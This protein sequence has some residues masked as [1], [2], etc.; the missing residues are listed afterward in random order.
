MLIHQLFEAQAERSP[1]ALAA[2]C[3]EAQLTYQELN[4]QANQLAHHLK[5][6]GVGPGVY[7]AVYM[8]RS[9][10]ILPALLGILKAGGAYV[11]LETSFP[12]ARVR[13]ILSSLHIPVVITH[14]AYVSSIPDTSHLP[15]LKHVICLNEVG[16]QRASVPI[17]T[18]SQLTNLPQ[19]NPFSQASQQNLAYV[20]FTSGSTGTPKGV[21]V[22]HQPVINLITWINTTFQVQARDRILFVTS[23][24]FD[25]SVYDVFGVLAVGGSI[26]IATEQDLRDPEQLISLLRHEPITF[27][28]SAP[29]VFQQVVP[30][31]PTTARGPETSQLRL[32]FL[33]GDWIP[34]GL[35]DTIRRTFARAQVVSL[36]GATETTVWS[37][38]HPI[39]VV[40][41]AW[42][43]IPYGWP[44][45]NI[46]CFILDSD[47]RPCPVGVDG[48][49]YVGGICLSNGYC[50]EPALT[51]EKF[52]PDPFSEE[53]G[54]RL[55]MTGD[56][57]RLWPDGNI[58]FLGRADQQV[59]VRGFRIELGEI[60][61][62]LSQYPI[63]QEVAVVAREYAAREKRLIA[64]LVPRQ[65]EAYDE[66]MGSSLP[67]WSGG[68]ALIRHLRQFLQE[69]L[70]EYMLPSAYML[71]EKLPLT[72]N[73][74]IDRKALPEPLYEDTD[75]EFVAPRTELEEAL[76]AVWASVLGLQ[77]V[78]IHDNFFLAGGHSL[79]ATLVITRVRDLCQVDLPLSSLFHAQTVASFANEVAA[80]RKPERDQEYFRIQ[81]VPRSRRYHPLSFPQEQV[82][83]LL[84]LA[85]QNMAYHFQA[86]LKMKG[87]LNTSA[88][89]KSLDEIIRRH[90]IF[91]TTFESLNG[92]PV[93]II[94][95]P[96]PVR[97]AIIDLCAVPE[98]ERAQLVQGILWQAFRQ[99]FAP[100]TLPLIRW[101]LL[102]LSEQEY[103]LTHIEH[104]LVHDGWSFN[105]FLHELLLLYRAFSEHQISPLPELPV[106][107]VDFVYWQRQWVESERGREQL[108]Y[109]TAQLAGSPPL[110]E[111]PIDHPRPHIQTF[112]GNV[113]RVAL[114]PRLCEALRACC[115]REGFTLYMVMLA[116]FLA[117][118]SRY[119]GQEDICLGTGIANRRSREA[120]LLIGMLINTVVLRADL[121]GNP[122][123]RDLLARVR[124]LTLEAYEHQD[125]PFEKV[126]AAL[127]PERDLSYNPFFQ[128]IFGFHDSPLDALELPGMELNL[129]EALS[130]GSA[131]FDLNLIVIPRAEQMVA[132]SP[133][134]KNADII[135]LWEYNSD[136]FE[137]ATMQRMLA[138]YQMLLEGVCTN[139][140]QR[141]ADVALL[142][143]EELRQQLVTWNE[144]GLALPVTASLQQ[145]IESWAWQAPATNALEYRGEQISYQ[146]LNQ[147]ANQ[148][149]HYLRKLGVGP[150]SLVGVCLG[151][152]LNLV[153]C[154]LAILKTGGAYL[155][156]DPA[157]PAERLAFM[158]QDARTVVLL[159]TNALSTRFA[160]LQERADWTRTTRIISLESE[161]EQIEQQ[162]RTGLASEITPDH[163]AYVIYTSGSTGNPKGVQITYR[164]LLNLVC[165]HQRAFSLTSQ[166]RTSQLASLSFD[167]AG[168][169]IWPSLAAGATLCIVDDETRSFPRRLRDWLVEQ[170]ITLS[171]LP[172]PLAESLLELEWPEKVALR[173]LL[174]GGDL[175][176][177]A[178]TS[179]GSFVLVN[180]YGPTEYSVVGTSG[181]VSPIQ[182]TNWQPSIG[183]PIA[184][185][186]VY[187][188]DHHMQPVPP[189]VAGE[190][191]LGGAGL[192]RG[193]AYR[194]DLTAERFLPDPFSQ[195]PGDRLY[196]TGDLV[197]YRPDGSLSFLGRNDE[198]VK[199]RGFRIELGEI[200]VALR[201]H[202]AIQEAL[203]VAREDIPGQKQLVAYL[204][205][206]T[207]QS[208]LMEQ[209]RQYLQD[210]FPSY[211]L[212]S[213]LVILEKLPL[214][215]NGKLDRRALPPPGS[216]HLQAGSIPPRT[217]IEELLAGMWAEVLGLQHVGI[218]ENF[219]EMGG[220]SLLATQVIARIH[221]LFQV[222][223]PLRSLF[224]HPCVAEL[225]LV[226]SHSQDSPQE[227]ALQRF[228]R[229]TR[230]ATQLPL[231]FA[232]QRLWFLHQL[233]PESPFYNISR[234]ITLTGPLQRTALAQSLNELVRRHEV[235]RTRFETPPVQII[236]LA[237]SLSLPVE[238]LA[239]LPEKERA[240][241]VQ[242]L[243]REEV[244]RPFDLQQGPL[245]RAKLLCLGTQEHMLLLSL[246]HIVSDGWSMSVL[247][248]ELGALYTAFCAGL[249]SPLPDLPLQYA[250]YALWQRTT[251][252]RE[253]WQAQL[254]YWK[255]QLAHL[256]QLALPTDR[257]RPATQTFAGTYE[258]FHLSSAITAQ[259]KALSRR[260]EVTLFM[261]LLAG[262]Q[263]LLARYSNQTDIVVGTGT[264]NRTRKELENLIG[265]FINTLV[266]RTDLSGDPSVH[267]LLG[268][269]RE[270]AL[271]AYA[272]QNLPFEQLVEELHP[273]RR[274][275]ANPLFQVIIALQN[276]PQEPLQLARLK[277]QLAPIHS[278][279]TKFDLH[280]SLWEEADGL[281]GML[282]YSTD[283]FEAGTIQRMLGHYQHILS[284]M[285]LQ[286]AQRISALPLLTETEL[287]QLRT[288][289]ATQKDYP[290]DTGLHR[291]FERQVRQTPQATAVSF[292]DEGIVTYEQLNRQANQLARYLC[293]A[294][295]RPGEPVGLYMERSLDLVISLLAI[296]KA[297]AAYAPLDLAYPR[298][299]VAFMIEDS[300]MRF[301]LTQQTLLAQLPEQ[302]A[303]ALCLD[304]EREKI[305]RQATSNLDRDLPGL[306]PAYVI[307]TSGSTG[308]PKGAIV[309][310]QAVARL[311]INT[312]YIQINA[313]DHFA[314]VSNA[315]FDAATFEIWG[316][317][318]HG[319]QLIGV[320]RD[321][322]L[323]PSAFATYL[324]EQQIT[325]IFLTAALFNQIAQQI[326]TAFNSLR[327]LLVG[328]EALTARWI[329]TVL[330][331]GRPQHLLNGYGPTENTTFSV[332]YHIEEV[333]EGATSL[334]IGFPIANTQAYVLDQH[335]RL[336]PAG[337]PAELYLGGDGL[338]LSYLR[339]PGVTAEHFVP[340]PF[341]ESAGARLYRTGDLARYLPDGK[342]EFLERLDT[343]IK[344][345]GFRIE[346]GE[347]ESVLNQYPGVQQSVVTLHEDTSEHKRLVAY[348]ILDPLALRAQPHAL[349]SQLRPYVQEKLPEY[350]VPSAF[351]PLDRLPLTPNGKVDR[352]SLPA[353]EI[354]HPETAETYVA[355]R[356]PAEELLAEIW[357]EVL[358]LEHVG[359]Q[360]NFFDLGGHSLLATQVIVRIREA[361]QRDV[362][363]HSLFEYP[364]VRGL[365]EEVQRRQW[366]GQSESVA[367]PLQPQPHPADLPLS[368]AQE[369]LWFLTQLEPEAPFY[370][371]A[372]AFTLTGSL[373]VLELERSLNELVSRH[374]A[375]RTR[376]VARRGSPIQ[377]I[378]PLLLVPLPVTELLSLSASEREEH[379]RSLA[380]EEVRSP[381]DLEVGPLLRIRLLRLA[382]NEHVL[383]LSM[384]H[385]IADGWSLGV[386]FR[387]L[388]ALY[389]AFTASNAVPSLSPLPN[390]PVQ[391]ADY[392]LWQNTWLSGAILQEQL[393]YWKRQ[394]AHLAPLALP[395][396]TPRPARQRFR[397][398]YRRFELDPDLT[399]GLKRLSRREGVTLFMTLLAGFHILLARYTGHNDLAVGTPIANRTRSELETLIGLFVNTLVLRGDLSGDPS[400]RELLRRIRL[401]TL[402]A[403]AH[404]DLPFEKL[405]E[406][407]NPQR[408]LSHH[409]L[410]QVMFALQ[411]APHSPLALTGVEIRPLEVEYTTSR[412]DLMLNLYEEAQGLAGGIE[413]DQD[414]FAEETIERLIG[415]YRH[416]LTGMAAQPEQRLS[417]LPLL[418]EVEYAQ[419]LAWNTT[420]SE[421]PHERCLH[422]LFEAQVAC[423]PEAVAIVCKDEQLTYRELNA[424][425]NQLAHY[426]QK[427]GV[428]PEMRVGIC[429]QRSPALVVGLLAILK[430]GGAYV[431]LDADYPAERLA[432][433]LTDARIAVL[434]TQQRLLE[435]LPRH[436]GTTLCLDTLWQALASQ[437]AEN[438]RPCVSAQNLAY[439]IYTSGSTGTP[440]GVL[441]THRATLNRLHW[442]WEHFP[443]AVGEVCCQKTS[444]SFVDSIWEIFGPL[445]R[446]VNTV[447]LADEIIKDPHQLVCTLAEQHITRI[448]LVPSL[449]RM[450]LDVQQNF[451][452][453]LA[454]T[455]YW[456]SSGEALPVEL[457]ERFL[458]RL[459]HSHL[460]NLYG[461]SE[462]AGDATCALLTGQSGRASVPIGRPI[463][464]TAAYVLDTHQ[465]LVPIGIPGELYLGGAGLA[466]G[467]LARPDLT[468]ERFLPDPFSTAPG[469]RMYRTGDRVRLLAQGDL[470][471]L[472]RLDHQVKLRGYRIEL[473]EI[474]EVL[475]QLSAIHQAVVALYDDD[476]ADQRLVAYIV[477]D[478]GSQLSRTQVQHELRAKLPEYMCP[479]T[480][481]FLPALPLTPNG[482]VDR[483][484]LPSPA[485]EQPDLQ[486]SYVAPNNP[487]E[488]ELAGLWADILGLQRIGIHDNFFANGGHSLLAVRLLARI[489]ERLKVE[490][491]VHTFFEAPTIIEQAIIVAQKRAEQA[492]QDDREARKPAIVA[493]ART[494]Y[495]A[496]ISAQG[497][498]TSPKVT[499]KMAT[500]D[501][502]TIVA[503]ARAH[504]RAKISAQGVLDLPEATRKI[505]A[506]EK[507]EEQ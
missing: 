261:T 280:L 481:I 438:L 490:L 82:W 258:P 370:T 24:C 33:S 465:H 246:H 347:I 472:G 64:Y 447:M 358:G 176:H 215:S 132:A 479:S 149:A 277:L 496:K 222:D 368:F 452:T 441:G 477:A 54:A 344:L 139:V 20:I 498:L 437:S 219:F 487:I 248:H 468:A 349:L 425:A 292:E 100:D 375:L 76:A 365:A 243:V 136:L 144:T 48:N 430:A 40:D 51:A 314:Q 10:D 383:L 203:V 398:R 380:R 265:F 399:T 113:F 187:L 19:Q 283:L 43:S 352:R 141:I 177:N 104:H 432:F 232:Q 7:V 417:A 105:T 390:L 229:A 302:G 137:A 34:V 26:H 397:G 294:G 63:I 421:Y 6:L 138:A 467:Y 131:K 323:S 213:A 135:L 96:W 252:T 315:A 407:I 237:L 212:P 266:L 445:L 209:V 167:A 123:F 328:G 418:T 369:R 4:V 226:I 410:F 161:K 377:V 416:I 431:P 195:Q 118:L 106:Q 129:T 475:G 318:L 401:M 287:V 480:Y 71:L 388:S 186:H 346:L 427:L 348:V 351:L 1:S 341:S 238:E 286:P 58:E 61:T 74:K 44:I 163:L 143:P 372:A 424:R 353:P 156:L 162:A 68:S 253:T 449:L 157:Y 53:P 505:L 69:R 185:T 197:R 373:H 385:L 330:A 387:E 235:L 319:A 95:D 389:A 459:P 293:Q 150:E 146:T 92:Q 313:A 316:A 321:V 273:Q 412:F 466:R 159:T 9:L 439:V 345:R 340:D 488:E 211:M 311:V 101:S 183:R 217:P 192:A 264:A 270:V 188:L 382:A 18:R 59:K 461:S 507:N 271:G 11:P 403:Y 166:D 483:A 41:P 420:G 489:S 337:I 474:E 134:E 36:G 78:G 395:T 485:W 422:E 354:I 290:R 223:L 21:M 165:W 173:T 381:F 408:S 413:Y 339:R 297:G 90:E 214:T 499:G 296:L 81:P 28:D 284:A 435:R 70:P 428:R 110:L 502:P 404:Q 47:F 205:Q 298:E 155:P 309:P 443:F 257:P 251:L 133:Q 262:F 471:F 60:E 306:A 426:L 333:P 276:A 364:T 391:Y 52:L 436:T 29:A 196:R 414:L 127:R 154:L 476:P 80:H 89:E 75:R 164:G 50:N 434:L 130:N 274:S 462:V 457:A 371:V 331:Q 376:F 208:V 497:M 218:F 491:S 114:P 107:F 32:V 456:V 242:E 125:L 442:M 15:A 332:C 62:I 361:F 119:T 503:V 494:Q 362:P 184:N 501:K 402:D 307:Y 281:G 91:R 324:Q 171:F 178:P 97:L 115:R 147:R 228:T 239:H 469:A 303:L 225:A 249:P 282:E 79:L 2:L 8:E 486:E 359:V 112:R 260:E 31:L 326:P 168:W 366:T 478:D 194:P 151:R 492:Q 244:Q 42:V 23:L 451:A 38:C 220:H 336:V 335:M 84:Q 267:E 221:N 400:V 255:Q 334:P 379:I 250:D 25:L 378:D 93:Q 482:K 504:Y 65:R 88:L 356:L 207:G 16:E 310:H 450:L 299:R 175:L 233:A 374:E 210:R 285:A 153:V 193:Y 269:V 55:Y 231:S 190:L 263:V 85:P 393:T 458:A 99:P 279:T 202:T 191:F 506:S 98:L 386:L 199:I 254:A 429:Q 278:S 367:P 87:P 460:L 342:I 444:L 256:P 419:L 247:F 198:Q 152:S 66:S 415:Q 454:Q 3:G 200:E 22:S 455:K 12:Q 355:P 322:L 77:R 448:V 14:Q 463:A 122:T 201:Q 312:N 396:D 241:R 124:T 5:A 145:M 259:L 103:L 35:P 142:T 224:E 268:R 350:M 470:E 37:N 440:K 357:A 411:N 72:T 216:N 406:E 272:H 180:N 108:A 363:L 148:L 240:A 27:W 111:L 423:T 182:K 327:F 206:K 102:R 172:T 305:S 158:L 495:R 360:D 500:S 116:A 126:V 325:M 117:L 343:Q 291:L 140:R 73:G 174:T 204:V 227:L 49:L 275:D 300:Q 13:W 304:R 181:T 86:M 493:V 94:H 473:G 392:A 179:P 317:L 46:R 308:I 338:A 245:L 170:R 56:L 120:E 409:P 384:H 320:S 289:N 236:D 234:T 128:V 45:Q 288:W 17:W 67:E 329:K 109:W 160:S 394:L 405:V 484:A 230:T 453:V 57:A 446:G 301:L 433:L 295:V 30:F 464:N 83:F 121:S 39:D 189:G 169:E